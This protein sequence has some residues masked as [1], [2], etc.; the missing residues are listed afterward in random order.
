LADADNA[1]ACEDCCCCGCCGSSGCT[2]DAV[3]VVVSEGTVDGIDRLKVGG[4]GCCCCCCW[5]GRKDPG[6]IVD[7]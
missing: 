4:N 1:A 7:A 6:R 2:G 5:V 3:S